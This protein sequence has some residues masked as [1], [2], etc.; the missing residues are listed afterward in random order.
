[1][2]YWGAMIS[3]LLMFIGITLVQINGKLDKII[4]KL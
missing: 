2:D 1:M 4:E 3:G